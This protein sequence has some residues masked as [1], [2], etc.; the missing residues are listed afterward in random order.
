MNHFYC[1]N[2]DVLLTEEEVVYIQRP[3]SSREIIC[4]HCGKLA[5]VVAEDDPH[6]E[7]RGIESRPTARNGF[8]LTVCF[9]II[10]VIVSKPGQRSSFLR[11]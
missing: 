6:N 5:V 8:G 10:F 1:P 11:E 9:T 4:V 3:S 2:E 7:S